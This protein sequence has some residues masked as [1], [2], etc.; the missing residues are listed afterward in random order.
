MKEQKIIETVDISTPETLASEMYR[1][2]KKANEFKN[3]IIKILCG[4]IALLIAAMTALHFYHIHKWSEYETIVVDSADG[5]NANYVGGENTG[6]I[7]NGEGYSTPQEEGNVQGEGS[8][9]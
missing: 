7:F 9:D 4:I 2:L 1:E 3:T 5:G 6:G 8:S